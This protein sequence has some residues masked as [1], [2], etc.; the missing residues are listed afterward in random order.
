MKNPLLKGSQAD[1]IP[2]YWPGI[3]TSGLVPFGR[4][5]LIRMDECST[6]TTGGIILTDDKIDSMTAASE[7]GCIF[8][9]GPAAFRRFD[10]GSI[11]TGDRPA[12]GD[13]VYVERYAGCVAKGRD[14]GLYRM[15]DANCI[16]GGLDKSWE[17]DGE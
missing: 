6:T 2:V 8:A 7:T 12:E 14:G 3:N 10:D 11:W 9:I 5:V 15:M 1:F 16:Y 17:G 4:H 13:R